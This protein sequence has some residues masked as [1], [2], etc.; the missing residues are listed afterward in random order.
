MKG[1]K[2]ATMPTPRM[3]KSKCR[4]CIPCIILDDCEKVHKGYECKIDEWDPDTECRPRQCHYY[5]LPSKTHP[6][7][8]TVK[9]PAQDMQG[10]KRPVEL[11]QKR[12]TRQRC[13]WWD[14]FGGTCWAPQP[15]PKAENCI[16][17]VSVICQ[18][19]RTG[20]GWEPKG[21]QP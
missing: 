8:T 2:E 10:V 20:C 21:G 16:M 3:P 13:R 11:P 1:S 4:Y 17:H 14:E 15:K 19:V 5:R 9:F 7:T 6:A 12:R 18:G